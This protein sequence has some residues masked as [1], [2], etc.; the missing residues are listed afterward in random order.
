MNISII[1]PVYNTERKKL[2]KCVSS[3]IKQDLESLEILLIDD[4]SD[5]LNIKYIDK[6]ASMDERVKLLRKKNGGVS[7]ARNLGLDE[8]KGEYIMFVDSDDWIDE[9][10]LGYLYGIAQEYK[11]DVVMWRHVKEF[12]EKSV[13]APIYLENKLTYD[14]WKMEFNPFD[15]RLMGMCWMKLYRAE[16]L[17]NI[18]FDTKLTNGEDVEF[19]FRVFEKMESAV[20]VNQTFYHY[21]QT[22]DSA[23]RA[24]KEDMP[25]RY[26]YTFTAMAR[27]IR[28]SVNNKT[29]LIKAYYSFAGIAYLVLNMNYIFAKGNRMTYHE[30]IRCLKRLSEKKP[31]S[32]AISMAEKLELPLTRKMAL[33]FAKYGF[34]HGIS[35]IMLVKKYMDGKSS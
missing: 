30:K 20:Y 24:F 5:G 14:S 15:M 7:S 21:R 26:D 22:S 27:D 8:A 13:E 17:K 4:G 10:C 34:Y 35:A 1:V 3:L 31:Y 32:K 18:R 28:K 33:I 23:V 25:A 16:L 9:D 11:S 6:I 2:E 19:N 12:E 29:Q